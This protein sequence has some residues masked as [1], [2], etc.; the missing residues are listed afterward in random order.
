MKHDNFDFG[1]DVLE[2]SNEVPV[3]V[4]YWSPT[5]GPCLFLGPILEK[6]ASQSSGTWELVKINTMEHNELAMEHGIYS[7]PHVKLFSKGKMVSEFV[8]ALPEGTLVKWLD[9]FIPT[10][11]KEQ[12]NAIRERLH[13]DD[14]D[15]ALADLKE[16]VAAHPDI[17]MARLVLASEIVFNTPAEARELVSTVKQGDLLWDAAE[18][19]RMLA[20]LSSFEDTTGTEAGKQVAA[21]GTALK[22]QDYEAA[23]VALLTALEADK[24]FSKELPRRGSIALFR[25]FGAQHP[26]TIK[27]RRRLETALQ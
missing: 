26:L 14:K 2:R 22:A 7:I 3:L 1:K 16:F 12:L 11:A 4:D 8:G 18:N 27:Y 13:G 10:E 24:G 15:K 6:L 19:V 17:P 20:E 25:M 9:E 23:M 5:C 21:A